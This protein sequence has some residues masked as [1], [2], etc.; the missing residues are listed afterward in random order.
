MKTQTTV[1]F[2]S[3]MACNNTI[4]IVFHS[5]DQELV[6]I[7]IDTNYIIFKLKYTITLVLKIA[8]QIHLNCLTCKNICL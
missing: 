7:S 5:I 6:T 1:K 2:T 3:I 4:G 8:S